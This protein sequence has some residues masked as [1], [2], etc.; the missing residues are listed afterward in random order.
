[1]SAKEIAAFLGGN[2]VFAGVP[3]RE[4]ETLARIAQEETHRARGE[5]FMEGDAARW[6]YLVRSRPRED[7]EA[8]QDGEGRGP[9]AAW[10]GGD[11]RGCGGDREAPLSGERPGHRG[12]RG[13]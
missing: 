9:R 6:V 8:F 7:R 4:L 5:I 12:H 2:P 11:L 13:R 10:A 3:E 1:M